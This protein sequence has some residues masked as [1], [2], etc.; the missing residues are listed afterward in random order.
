MIGQKSLGP[1]HLK[2]VPTLNRLASIY[3]DGQ[4]YAEAK[5]LYAR[6][7]E[8]QENVLG[9]E[10]LDTAKT[11]NFLMQLSGAGKIA[12]EFSPRDP[13]RAILL[14]LRAGTRLDDRAEIPWAR[15]LEGGPDPQPP[16]V[17]L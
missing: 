15:A 14:A 5:Q 16:G 11:L 9:S 12:E 8:I 2:V 7:L 1:E 10:H 3:E 6:A 13:R 4:K 17:D